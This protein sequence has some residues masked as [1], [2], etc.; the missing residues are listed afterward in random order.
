MLEPTALYG[1]NADFLDALYEQYLRDP[2]SVAL[3]VAQLLR[4]PGTGRGRARA[5]PG[6]GGHCRARCERHRA[7]HARFRRR[8]A[9]GSRLAPDPG[10]DQPRSPAGEH[11]SAGPR[12]ASAAARAGPGLLR[13]DAGGPGHR[14]LHRQP[15][16][17][18]P[19]AHEAARHPRA[20]CSTSM[21][22][23]SAR[24]SRTCPTRTSGCGC[25]TSSRTGACKGSFTSEERR[26]I[27]WQLTAAEGLERYLHTKYV[28]QKRFS[29]EGG[30][31]LIPLLDDLIQ[32]A[33]PPA[34]RKSSSA[35]PIA[36]GS[37]CW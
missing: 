34:S 28:G 31:A 18:S 29:L 33:A 1:G 15:H 4:L 19:E 24:S 5:C 7:E 8:C 13:T 11:R 2:G 22:A 27:L 20:C 14:V 9:P 32:Q 30:D 26:N 23:T 12:A 36:A 21:R 10:V 3:A 35:W 37:T 17:G 6:E 16:R 25:R